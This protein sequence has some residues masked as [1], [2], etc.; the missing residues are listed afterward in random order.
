MNIDDL[1]INDAG[2]LVEKVSRLT[3]KLR[4]KYRMVL[5]IP[6]MIYQMHQLGHGA[7]TWRNCVLLTW[8]SVQFRFSLKD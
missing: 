7:L 8:A 2:Q 6:K 1:D 4:P 3:I 5:G